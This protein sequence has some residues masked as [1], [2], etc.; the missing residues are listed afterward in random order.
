[1]CKLKVDAKS[2]FLYDDKIK[3]FIKNRETIKN[4]NY[5]VKNYIE[6]KA[7]IVNAGKCHRC[8]GR[9]IKR[10]GKAEEFYGVAI[11]PGYG[12]RKRMD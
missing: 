10:Q 5:N 1:M 7:N 4:Y 9:L 3:D 6:Y 8:D 11:I 12:K 2:R